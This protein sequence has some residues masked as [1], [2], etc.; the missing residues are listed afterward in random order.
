[1]IGG[2]HA[3]VSPAFTARARRRGHDF[4]IGDSVSAA[5]ESERQKAMNRLERA[6]AVETIG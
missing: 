6:I 5:T 3:T 2:K 1:M 4:E